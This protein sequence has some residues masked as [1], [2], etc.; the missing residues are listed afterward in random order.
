MRLA[1]SNLVGNIPSRI[2]GYRAR[3]GGSEHLFSRE[4]LYSTAFIVVIGMCL[5]RAWR[6]TVAKD[7]PESGKAQVEERLPTKL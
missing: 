1:A 2:I 3:G 5:Q 6:F 7:D 4:V